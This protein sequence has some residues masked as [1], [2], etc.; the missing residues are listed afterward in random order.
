[1]GDIGRLLW[2]WSRKNDGSTRFCVDYR[3]LNALTVKTL[4][5]YRILMTP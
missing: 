2:F 3:R 4:T 5:R 1:M